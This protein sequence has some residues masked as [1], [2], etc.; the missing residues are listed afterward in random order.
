M[1]FNR[2]NNQGERK[3]RVTHKRAEIA[4]RTRALGAAL[5][6]SFSKDALRNMFSQR[7]FRAGGYTA[8]SC[9]IVIAIAAAAVWFVDSL[10][11][12]YTNLDISENQVTSIS[13]DTTDY[14]A[15]IEDDITIY[16]IAEEGQEDDY[17]TLLLDKYATAS[18][19]IT[20]EQK[21]PA[22][23]PAFTSQY[24]DAELSDNSLIIVDGDASRVLDYYDIYTLDSS[25]T[26]TFNGEPAITSAIKAL[27]SDDLPQVYTLTGHGESEL[28]SDVASQLELANYETDSLSLLT[29]D[30]V[31]ED[32]D[33]VIIYAPQSDLSD[34]EKEA[35]LDYLEGGGSLLLMTDYDDD[36]L[37][38]LADLMNAYGLEATWGAVVE[39]D[40]SM[41]V[42]GYPYYLLPTIEEHDVTASFTGTNTYVLVPLAHGIHAIDQYRSSLSISPLLSTSTS[43]YIK[44]D[45]ANAETLEQEDGDV[46]GQT[47]LGAAVTEEVDEG[48]TRVAWYG[49][50]GM[51][52]S[53]I[54]SLVGGND[55]QLFVDTLTWLC[56][57]EGTASSSSSK[58]LS[59]STLVMDETTS[60]NLSILLVAVVPLVFLIAGFRIWNTRR[61]R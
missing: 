48:T 55:S 44:T 47:W 43:A 25:Y 23:Y 50:T 13:D 14:L 15:N 51:L 58:D 32:A 1:N 59:S 12:S 6:A 57:A 10:P 34:Q 28:P 26:Y 9:V 41:H 3:E 60:S 36:D 7:S 21:D 42:T 27:T 53:Q 20:V 56:D 2:K 4:R 39:G 38:N 49:S 31:P 29:E 11:S 18:D 8:L 30:A 22:L 37:P 61:K 5:K 46:A 33:A 17:L 54:D 19:H 52:D 45:I 24:T 16:L 35:L 40:S